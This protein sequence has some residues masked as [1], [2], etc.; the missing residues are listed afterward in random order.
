MYRKDY[1]TELLFRLQGAAY[2]YQLSYE[3]DDQPVEIRINR[4][5]TIETLSAKYGRIATIDRSHGKVQKIGGQ[6]SLDLARLATA[7]QLSV[8][9]FGKARIVSHDGF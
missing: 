7:K 1:T 8:P 6:A 4:D 5:R 2:T 3:N 9:G